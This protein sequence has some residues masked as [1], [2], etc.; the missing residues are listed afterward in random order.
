MRYCISVIIVGS[1]SIS[2]SFGT[3]LLSKER[4]VPDDIYQFTDMKQTPIYEIMY[5]WQIFG[6]MDIKLSLN[7]I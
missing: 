6:F 2:V 1:I 5:L 7:R 3:S 4:E